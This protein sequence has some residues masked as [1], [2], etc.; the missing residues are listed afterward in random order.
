MTAAAAVNMTTPMT[1]KPREVLQP[2]DSPRVLAM[3][4]TPVMMMKP[5]EV[6]ADVRELR[7][8]GFLIPNGPRSD[9]ILN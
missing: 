2:A 3:I 6:I 4:S 7:N 8:K 9:L 1:E 5:V